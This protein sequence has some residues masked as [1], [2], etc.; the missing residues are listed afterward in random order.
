MATFAG[1]PTL[2]VAGR[3]VAVT[4]VAFSGLAS[5]ETTINSRFCLMNCIRLSRHSVDVVAM[6][7]TQPLARRKYT[8]LTDHDLLGYTSQ[9][10]LSKMSMIAAKAWDERVHRFPHGPQGLPPLSPKSQGFI[11]MPIL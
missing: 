6:H 2:L 4:T 10:L 11:K 8:C 9:T 7:G 1:G 3:V 5:Y